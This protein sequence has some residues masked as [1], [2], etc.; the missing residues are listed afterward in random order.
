MTI[1]REELLKLTTVKTSVF[2]VPS[3]KGAEIKLRELTIA[4]VKEFG[5]IATEIDM[6]QAILH[7]C[8]CSFVEPSFFTD[9]EMELL[10]NIG[11]NVIM[12]VFNEIPLIGKNKE[13][14]EE[15]LKKINE[16]LK[17]ETAEEKKEPKKPM[18][19]KSENSSLN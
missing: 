9:E 4:E 14:R 6:Q 5:R 17:T 19:K 2:K 16:T 10:G 11:N 1:S 18:P 8:K 13:E 15:H 7:A 12:E 3:L